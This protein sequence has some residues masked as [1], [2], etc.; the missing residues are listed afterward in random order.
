MP[1]MFRKLSKVNCVMAP[2]L[3]VAAPVQSRRL[4]EQG[5]KSSIIP[6]P[7]RSSPQIQATVTNSA[8]VWPHVESHPA[9]QCHDHSHTSTS[10]FKA[11]CKKHCSH[12]RHDTPLAVAP[13]R[14]LPAGLSRLC[15][16]DTCEAVFPALS[17][18][19]S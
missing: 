4:T 5:A 3:S 16:G 15:A 18:G 14:H 9:P 17:L 19:D 8:S 11:H 6:Q 2:S 10:S 7:Q 13:A 1:K 12:E